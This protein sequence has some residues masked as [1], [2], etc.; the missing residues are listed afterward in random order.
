MSDALVSPINNKLTFSGHDT[1]H[2][3]QLWLKK[4][5]DF[6]VN[7]NKFTDNESV[8]LLGVGKNMVSAIHFWMRAF[9][10]FTKDGSVTE[11][12]DYIF[13]ENGKDP[14]LED[15]ATLWLLHYYLVTSGYASTYD[16]IFNELRKEKIEFSKE[17]F[18][19]FVERKAG[20]L[21]FTQFN[22]KTVSTDFDVLTKMYIRTTEQ[23]KDKEDTLSGLLTD[24]N[25]IQEERKSSSIY[26]IPN[27][28]RNSLPEE[29][30]LYTILDKAEFQNS[31]NLN[32]LFQDKNLPGSV[33]AITKN[34]LM[35]KLDSI[36][37]NPKYKKHGITISD[38]AGI[39][40]LQFVLKPNKFDILN[41]YYG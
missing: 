38:H 12:A 33:F 39:K 16:L 19:S 17:N 2:C 9:G 25:L 21:G 5:Y 40:E 1:F 15:E 35:D 18:L 36:A 22:K 32:T 24:L 3:R 29:I 6:I 23:A 26:S 4:G 31:I 30:V 37:N 14:Y 34:A 20:D 28:N 41:N 13:S 8:I 11:F 10:L 7:G 27:D